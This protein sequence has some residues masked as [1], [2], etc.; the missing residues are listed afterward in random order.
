MTTATT[1][2]TGNYASF[3]IFFNLKGGVTDDSG[4]GCIYQHNKEAPPQTRWLPGHIIH[5]RHCT[6]MD[7]KHTATFNYI[8]VEYF[9]NDLEKFT[10]VTGF[11]K[12]QATSWYNGTVTPKKTTLTYILNCVFTPEFKVITEFAEFNPEEEIRPQLREI[13]GDH[14]HDSGLYAFYDSMAML[15]YLGKATNLLNESYDAILR[16]VHIPFPK[17]VRNKPD[18]RYELV[19]YIS[20]YQVRKFDFFDYPRHV[21]SL[22]LRISKPA[23]NKNIG[24]IEKAYQNLD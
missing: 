20:Y 19:R 8:F 16:S 5:G 4:S 9:N 11:S 21:E 14:V 22:I 6:E 1:D 12:T 13:L 15:I 24:T 18:Q 23:L 3:H 7:T 10:D 17:G 2:N